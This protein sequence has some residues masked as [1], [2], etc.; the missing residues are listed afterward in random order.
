MF[1]TLIA[2]ALNYLFVIICGRLLEPLEFGALLSGI[3]IINLSISLSNPLQ[4]TVTAKVASANDHLMTRQI[5]NQ[6]FKKTLVLGIAVLLVAPTILT[7][8]FNNPL[9]GNVFGSI[10]LV[11]GILSVILLAIANGGLSAKKDFAAVATSQIISSIT[12]IILL[13]TIFFLGIRADRISALAIYAGGFS[14]G[15]FYATQKLSTTFSIRTTT[16]GNQQ[17]EIN[18]HTLEN[19]KKF[20]ALSFS[21]LIT[22]FIIDQLLIYLMHKELSGDYGALMTL[23]KIPFF[24]AAPIISALLPHLLSA[25]ASKKITHFRSACLLTLTLTAPPTILMMSSPF[26]TLKLSYG[27]KYLML[28]S[29]LSVAIVGILAHIASY[30]VMQLIVIEQKAKVLLPLSAVFFIQIVGFLLSNANIKSL[31]YLQTTIYILQL[32]FLVP[33][34]FKTLRKL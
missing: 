30:L 23:A 32:L 33:A 24:L 10:T 27:T 17:I 34:F 12:R 29:S 16:N 22:P 4:I 20:F 3:A 21:L 15:A 26:L 1:G 13:A 5:I 8:F 11:V 31:I 2:S 25:P 14:V 7:I 6:L 18:N 28:S 9:L 19:N